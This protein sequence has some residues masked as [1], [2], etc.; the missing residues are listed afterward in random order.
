MSK[1]TD[2][3]MRI[4]HKGSGLHWNV[5]AGL[6]ALFDAKLISLPVDEAAI[7]ESVVRECIEVAQDAVNVGG[8]FIH[9]AASVKKYMEDALI[10]KDRAE[11]LAEEFLATGTLGAEVNRRVDVTNA[12]RWLIEREGAN[13]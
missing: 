10:P 5:K 11:E 12:F 1:V 4:F 9:A 13:G 7:R 6:Q 3:M 2:E 8:P